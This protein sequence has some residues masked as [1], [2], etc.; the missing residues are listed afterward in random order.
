[1]NDAAVD[2]P[3]IMELINCLSAIRRNDQRVAVVGLSENFRA[4]FKMVGVARFGALYDA[5]PVGLQSLPMVD[6]FAEQAAA[7]RPFAR[8][9][10]TRANG[11]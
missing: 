11:R 5:E 2:G 7:H 8:I 4:I 3:G 1:M 9:Q 10:A 6:L